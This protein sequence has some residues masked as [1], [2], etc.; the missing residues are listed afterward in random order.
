M[1][2]PLTSQATAVFGVLFILSDFAV[3]DGDNAINPQAAQFTQ[4]WDWTIP[5][6]DRDTGI[7]GEARRSA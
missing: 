3:G 2:T 5:V 7:W 6:A 4:G 1:P